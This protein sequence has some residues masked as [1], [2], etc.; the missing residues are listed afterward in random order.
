VSLLVFLFSYVNWNI[1][2]SRR[3][4]R[5][6][7]WYEFELVLFGGEARQYTKE[8]RATKATGK[9]RISLTRGDE[10][11]FVQ[12]LMRQSDPADEKTNGRWPSQLRSS[13]LL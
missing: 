13:I 7:P 6:K 10:V 8:I 4:C 9:R 12:R 3:E 2:P 11:G 5:K 1:P